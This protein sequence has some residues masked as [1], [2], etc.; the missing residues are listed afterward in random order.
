M[1]DSQDGREV[2][3]DKERGDE[4]N[5]EEQAVVVE[6]RVGGGLELGN[7]VLL[8][9]ET[10]VLVLLALLV[11]LA[12]EL[13]DDGVLALL[14]NLV[15]E[16][17]LDVAIGEADQVGGDKSGRHVEDVEVPRLHLMDAPVQPSGYGGHD[18]RVAVEES[19]RLGRHVTAVVVEQRLLFGGQL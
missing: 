19:R 16:H 13:L 10:V 4:Q 7:L 6:D 17:E 15:L 1:S 12:G 5:D 8:P 9:E 11:H 3:E 2:L 14:R 18:D